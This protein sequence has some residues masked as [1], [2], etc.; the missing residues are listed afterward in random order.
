[1]KV[2]FLE[3]ERVEKIAEG[4]ARNYLLPRKLAILATP[5]ALAASEKRREKRKGVIDAKRAELQALADKLKTEDL[6]ISME[7]GEGGKLFGSVTTADV[8]KAIKSTHNIDIDK[9]KINLHDQ[10]KTLGEHGVTIKLFQ[11]ISAQIKIKVN[12][13]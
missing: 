3:D 7:A 4:Y 12:P 5:K 10:I 6:Q 8:A 1:M 9:R 13:K 2:I 11:D